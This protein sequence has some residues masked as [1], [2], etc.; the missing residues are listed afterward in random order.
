M[1]RTLKTLIGLGFATLVFATV[2]GAGTLKGKVVAVMSGDTLTLETSRGKL[3]KVRLK[4]VDTPELM[5]PFGRQARQFSMDLALAKAVRVEYEKADKYLRVIGDVVL[6]DGRVL[7]QEL[8]RNG[9]AWQYR[10]HHPANEFLREL[11]YGAWKNKEG[12]WVEPSALPPWEFRRET[13]LPVPPEN[14]SQMDYDRIFNYG[15]IGDPETKTYLW[16]G[17]LNYPEKSPGF[18]VFGNKQDAEESGF[19]ISPQCPGARAN[20]DSKP[21]P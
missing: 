16:P 7:N 15:L 9:L 18:A 3:I 6:P 14:R 8:L 10:V 2:S 17:C 4:E 11:E 1:K 13:F 5:Q 12:L 20:T 19:K 21:S